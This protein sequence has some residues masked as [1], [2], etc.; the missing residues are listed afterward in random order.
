M[1]DLSPLIRD[2]TSNPHFGRWSLNHW[3]T[4][5]IHHFSS[6]HLEDWFR[7][8]LPYLSV[9][10]FKF[11]VGRCPLPIFPSALC[12]VLMSLWSIPFWL[13]AW[14]ISHLPSSPI[15]CNLQEYRAFVSFVNHSEIP[16]CLKKNYWAQS[17]HSVNIW[18]MTQW[19]LYLFMV[20]LPHLNIRPLGLGDLFFFLTAVLPK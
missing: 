7:V 18:W 4:R 2:R 12:F 5:E 10:T 6:L 14:L 9:Y 17:S 16:Q 19:S 20:Y 13:T 15:E 11:P 8:G 1:W 3:T